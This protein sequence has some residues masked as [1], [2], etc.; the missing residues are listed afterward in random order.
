MALPLTQNPY[1]LNGPSC[2]QMQ[3]IK[4]M[5]A[6]STTSNLSSVSSSTL[7]TWLVH[8]ISN[9]CLTFFSTPF[10]ITRED[11]ARWRWRSAL[12]SIWSL[13][14][15]R[16]CPVWTRRLWRKLW[17]LGQEACRLDKLGNLIILVHRWVNWYQCLQGAFP[18]SLIFLIPNWAKNLFPTC[19]CMWDRV[20]SKMPALQ[21]HRNH[22]EG[23][24]FSLFKFVPFAGSEIGMRNSLISRQSTLLLPRV[25]N[26]NTVLNPQRYLCVLGGAIFYSM[27]HTC[28]R[29]AGASSSKPN[30][31]HP[32]LTLSLPSSKMYILP[33]FEREMCEGR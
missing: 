20:S 28:M 29:G 23:P 15:R 22:S 26:F 18:H 9:A 13:F 3:T 4:Q 8:E 27:Y 1:P 24:G 6:S 11:R 25:I 30:L 5:K 7:S 32:R 31:P 33:T 17:F 19:F 10:G 12:T 16:W 21:C 2:S 14:R